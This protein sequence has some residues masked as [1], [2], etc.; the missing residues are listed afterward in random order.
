VWDLETGQLLATLEGHTQEVSDCAVTPDGRHAVSVSDDRTLRVWDLGTY[1]CLATHRGDVAFTAVAAT[2][3]TICAG[4]W[5]GT[6]W[7]LDWPAPASPPPPV[8]ELPEGAALAT[9]TTDRSRPR[10]SP[11]SRNLILFL[12]ANPHDTSPIALDE[13]CAAIERELRMTA[14]RDDFEF[15]S[16]WAVN[17]DDLG[18]HLMELSPT[19]IH[20]SGH[21]ARGGAGTSRG[22][23]GI[24]LHGEPGGSQL[25]TGRAL[26]MMIRSA[27]AAARVVVLNACYSE[28]QAD[29]LRGVVDCVIGMTGAIRDDAARSFAVGF[30]RALGNRRSVGN[31]VEHAVA[32]L[33]AKQLPDEHLP[34]C[35]T[36][37]GGDANQLVLGAAGGSAACAPAAVT[38]DRRAATRARGYRRRTRGGPARTRPRAV[39]GAPSARGARPSG[40]R[41]RCRAARTLAGCSRARREPSLTARRRCLYRAGKL[42]PRCREWKIGRGARRVATPRYTSIHVG[43]TPVARVLAPWPSPTRRWS[44]MIGDAR[45][46]SAMIGPATSGS[47]TRQVRLP[48]SE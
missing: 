20:F 35:R 9:G 25:V 32:T 24:Y 16:K 14:H 3:T 19:I 47:R 18:R 26:A 7:F 45:Q 34:R 39:P 30:Y 31:A 48:R 38:L 29:A 12:A 40:R 22:G 8:R 4:D 36:R 15:R 37:A 23:S 17:V 2:A 28:A 42:D 6:F 33:A 13:E 10:R 1:R 11:M 21:G 5:V 44:A 27:A 41:A 46:G 43:L